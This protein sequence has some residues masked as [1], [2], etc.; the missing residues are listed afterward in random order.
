MN[1]A[2]QLNSC[3][4]FSAAL[5]RQDYFQIATL[6]MPSWLSPRAYSVPI[7]AAIV[8]VQPLAR[9]RSGRKLSEDG[10]IACKNVTANPRCRDKMAVGNYRRCQ[11]IG[12]YLLT[13]LVPT[14]MLDRLADRL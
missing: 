12:K 14:A 4:H 11:D 3:S 13:H 1:I 6:L 8:Q 10:G 5:S 7:P 9:R 2:T